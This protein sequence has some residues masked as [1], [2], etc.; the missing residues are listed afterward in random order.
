M[1]SAPGTSSPG[2]GPKLQAGLVACL[3]APGRSLVR[4]GQRWATS[5]SGSTF[6]SAAVVRSMLSAGLLE[7]RGERI[8]ALTAAGL[9]GAIEANR[10]ARAEWDARVNRVRAAAAGVRI[11]P[12]RLQPGRMPYAD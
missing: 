5:F 1:H 6:V 11:N 3:Q 2:F 12:S 4:R 9:A 7:Q 8:V 10:L